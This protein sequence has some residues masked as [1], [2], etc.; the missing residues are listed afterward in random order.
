[1]S[2]ANNTKPEPL[3]V[4]PRQALELLPIGNTKLY[5]AINDGIIQ[6]TLVNGRRWINFQSLKRFAGVQ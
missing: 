3:A 4:S 5:E 6:S 1:M 2:S